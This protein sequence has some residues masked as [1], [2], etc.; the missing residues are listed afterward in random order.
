[1]SATKKTNRQQ[2]AWK[3]E[4]HVDGE[5][6]AQLQKMQGVDLQ[7]PVSLAFQWYYNYCI[8]WL[9][10][11]CTSF[12]TSDIGKAMWK[13]IKFDERLLLTDMKGLVPGVTG[14]E[15]E[16][17][18]YQVLVQLLRTI[19]QNKHAVF[20]DWDV[21]VKY[22]LRDEK[23]VAFY[24]GDVSFLELGVAEQFVVLYKLIKL[25]ERKSLVFKN[26][27]LN[28]EYLFQFPQ[29]WLDD[30]TSF[31]ILP[32]SKIVKKEIRKLKDVELRIPIKLQNCTVRYEEFNGES[33]DV[34]HYDYAQDIETYLQDVDV[35]YTV[36]AYNWAT[37]LEYIGN[38]GDKQLQEFFSDFVHYS[39][40]NELY[41]LKLWNNRVKE[42]SMQELIVRR[43]R[44]SRLVAREEETQRKQVEESWHDKLDDRDRY[45][46]LRNKLV[47]KQSKK[48]K[49]ALWS[50]LWDRFEYDKKVKKVKTR[51]IS[52]DDIV[53]GNLSED[54][55][56]SYQV[57]DSLLTPIE[58]DV[59]DHGETY[60]N[61]IVDIRQ[62]MNPLNVECQEL[63][64]EYCIT[65]L[66][67]K[68][69]ANHGIPT[70]SYEE[71][72]KDWYFQCPCD[73]EGINM[74]PEDES[75]NGSNIICCDQCLR[76]QH[77]DC[78]HKITLDF[79][80]RGHDTPLTSKDFSLVTLGVPNRR[81][82]RRATGSGEPDHEFDRPT[83]KRKP[84]TEAEIFICTWCLAK[85]EEDLRSIF[86]PELVATRAKEKKQAEEKEKRRLMKEKK[87]RDELLRL[88][89]QQQ[90]QQQLYQ[91]PLPNRPMFQLQSQRDLQPIPKLTEQ[92]HK[93]QLQ[94]PKQVL[95]IPTTPAAATRPTPHSQLAS[96]R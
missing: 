88:Q 60:K 33:L 42:R 26:Y 51:I 30:R 25:V 32:G 20:E 28:H 77:W 15:D 73:I 61:L 84:I 39:A 69:L 21:T 92:Q 86:K 71:D 1:M 11:I 67:L 93:G 81:K 75:L 63:T 12:W 74:D 44:S 43:K 80:S 58:E 47:A 24:D 27:L 79:L 19:S 62:P 68:K 2:I 9:Y 78:Q 91:Q 48:V 6:L 14:E 18:Y 57:G 83:M 70:D 54:I 17:L 90:Q 36:V 55:P 94:Q 22:Y 46:R 41:Q 45:I 49:D 10:N 40:A 82:S 56:K 13:D 4:D 95:S 23:D 65:K 87:K 16:N 50:I 53:G 31:F 76:W 85:T 35:H 72:S 66:D 37:F 3:W 5:V 7:V 96:W 29:I 59:L 34:V 52:N 89:Q 8:G 38:V 64:D